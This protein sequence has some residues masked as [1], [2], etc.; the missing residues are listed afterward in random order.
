MTNLA[1]DC[2]SH[3]TH[4]TFLFEGHQKV[5][6]ITTVPGVPQVFLKTKCFIYL[7]EAP[8]AKNDQIYA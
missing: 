2:G 3:I 6:L 5:V 8:G 7:T 1:E 4:E